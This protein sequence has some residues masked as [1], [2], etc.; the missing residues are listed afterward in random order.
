MRPELAHARLQAR[1]LAAAPPLVEGTQLGLGPRSRRLC[2]LLGPL[3]PPPRLAVVGS[4]AAHRAYLDCLPAV[5]ELARSRGWSLVSGGA[6]GI[7]GGAH[8]AA[9]DRRVAQLAVLPC[10]RDQPYPSRHAAL[11]TAMLDA[12]EAGLLFAQPVGT[13]P[14]RAMFASRNAIVVGLASAVLVVEARSRSG[15]MGTGRLALGRGVPLAAVSGSAG[16]GRLIAAGARG[17]PRPE[18]PTHRDLC[19][20]LDTFLGAALDPQRTTEEPTRPW[21]EALSDLRARLR[22]AGPRGLSIDACPDPEGTLSQLCEAELL[23]LVTEAT[24]GRWVAL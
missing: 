15:T 13:S 3:P 21:P 2:E 22:A 18:G 6:L 17:L 1:L 8:Q 19:A 11:F 5:L 23:G 24:P 9:L 12:P 10:G 7:D 14:T 20:A 4:R 16:A